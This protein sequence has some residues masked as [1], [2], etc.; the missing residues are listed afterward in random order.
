MTRILLWGGII[1]CKIGVHSWDGCKCKRCGK[2]RDEQPSKTEEIIEFVNKANNRIIIT[3]G[4]LSNTA[5]DNKALVEALAKAA[6]R[7]VNVQIIT[8]DRDGKNPE[9]LK[10]ELLSKKSNLMNARDNYLPEKI[11]IYS[12]PRLGRHFSLFDDAVM[13]ET[14]NEVTEPND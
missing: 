3:V 10:N 4:E 7:G 1:L 2:K 6:A 8:G 11:K 14:E 5:F 9:E 12:G 13:I